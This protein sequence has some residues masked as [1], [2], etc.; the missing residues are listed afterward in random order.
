M[1]L[2]FFQGFIGGFQPQAPPGQGQ[3]YPNAPN[4]PGNQPYVG[5]PSGQGYPPPQGYSPAPPQGYYPPPQAY[6]GPIITQPGS[7]NG[8]YGPP[9]SA[10]GN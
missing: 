9:P 6:G 10:Q 8:G 1:S 3:P 5:P 2:E 4:F 7:G